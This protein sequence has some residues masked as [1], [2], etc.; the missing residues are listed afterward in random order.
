MCCYYCVVL[1]KAEFL[2]LEKK[3][4]QPIKYV[5]AEEHPRGIGKNTIC[6][7]E[8]KFHSKQN[9]EIKII[10]LLPLTN[11]GSPRERRTKQ[12]VNC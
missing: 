9:K 8:I 1:A 5:E 10:H 11:Y 12:D 7:S 4:A 6:D 2:E 3:D